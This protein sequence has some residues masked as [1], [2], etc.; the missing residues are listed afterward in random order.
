M[1]NIGT[2]VGQCGIVNSKENISNMRNQLAF[3]ASIA[4]INRCDAVEK[5][6]KIN[7][8]TGDDTR[9]GHLTLGTFASRFFSQKH[10]S[11]LHHG[12]TPLAMAEYT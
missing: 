7:D 4:D 9:M 1:T 10:L 3:S 5:Q 6:M 2:L 11:R 8:R 12:A